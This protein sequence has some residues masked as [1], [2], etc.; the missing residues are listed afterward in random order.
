MAA[1]EEEYGFIIQLNSNTCIEVKG[2]ARM[3]KRERFRDRNIGIPEGAVD[4]PAG[5][6]N[7][8]ARM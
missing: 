6:G 2:A 8:S 3:L 1:I 7:E 4:A 5:F